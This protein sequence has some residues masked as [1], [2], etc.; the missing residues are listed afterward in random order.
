MELIYEYF[1]EICTGTVPIALGVWTFR[2][3]FQY[4]A[5]RGILKIISKIG[6]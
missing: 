1:Y 3:I 6:F 4:H 5:N 2:E